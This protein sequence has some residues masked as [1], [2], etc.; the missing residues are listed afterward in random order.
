MPLDTKY[1]R[2]VI[3]PNDDDKISWYEISGYAKQLN[4]EVNKDQTLSDGVLVPTNYFATDSDMIGKIYHRTT[5]A[6][7]EGS[8]YSTSIKVAVGDNTK[9]K[10]DFP[11]SSETRSSG[12]F[13]VYFFNADGT[14]VQDGTSLSDACCFNGGSIILDIPF[15]AHSVAIAFYNNVDTPSIYLLP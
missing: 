7:T 10:I 11:N 8:I 1:C 13:L 6:V 14:L 3:T 4:I 15:N 5:G 2:V 9:V 12:S